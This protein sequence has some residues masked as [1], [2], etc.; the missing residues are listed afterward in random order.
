[1]TSKKCDDNDDDWNHLT[2]FRVP[3]IL[4]S[5]NYHIFFSP[6]S[7]LILNSK[8]RGG[9]R[10]AF[11]SVHWDLVV[12]AQTAADSGKAHWRDCSQGGLLKKWLMNSSMKQ[13]KFIPRASALRAVLLGS[14]SSIYFHC[15]LSPKAIIKAC[16]QIPRLYLLQII[17][18]LP[19]PLKRVR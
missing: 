6:E 9:R 11:H 19:T 3:C 16:L 18:G 12:T 2:V 5:C 15:E 14:L 8:K 10:A 13:F 17:P 7:F 1:M 4:L